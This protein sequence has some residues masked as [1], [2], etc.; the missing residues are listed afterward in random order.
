MTLLF[1]CFFLFNK[2]PKPCAAIAELL[3]QS[4]NPSISQ[5]LL[6]P[7]KIKEGQ[8]RQQEKNADAL[9]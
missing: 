5:T 3:E 1:K 7:E 2:I 6:S 9:R 4:K 8:K